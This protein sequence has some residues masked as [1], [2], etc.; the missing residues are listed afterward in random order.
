MKNQLLIFLSL[1][2]G[3][4]T[5]NAQSTCGTAL[6]ASLGS[7]TAS[8]SSST[9]TPVPAHCQFSNAGDRYIWYTFT[10][11]IDTS[12]RVSTVTSLNTGLDT[13]ISIFDGSCSALSC[14]TYGD[15]ES[16]FLTIVEFDAEA[17][18]TYYIVFD[19]Y[20]NSMPVDFTIEQF[21]GGGGGGGGTPTAMI[22]FTPQSMGVSSEC[23]VDM[24]ND[25]FD[26]IVVP[27]G[28]SLSI[29]YQSTSVPGTFTTQNYT[30]SGGVTNAPS[31]SIAGGDMDNNGYTDL[32]YGG[33]NGASIIMA[34]ST[35]TAYSHFAD[36]NYIFS[37]RTNVVD[38][39][40]NGVADAFVCHDVDAN[41]WYE[42][43]GDGTFIHHQGGLGPNAGNY[44]SVWIDYDND[45]DIDLFIAKCGSDA[46][47]QLHRNNGDGTFTSVGAA[48]GIADA[49]QTWSSA[50]A[51][52]DNDGDM[53]AFIGAS[54]SSSGSHKFYKNNGDGTF[55]NITAGSGFDDYPTYMGIENQPVD[56]NNDGWV[57]VYGLGGL[58]MFNNG[59]M[60]F[61]ASTVPAYAGATGDLN[62][63]GA[64]DIVYGSSIYFNDVDTNNY[65]IVSTVGVQS[66]KQGIGARIT[67]HSDLGNQI[68][69]VRSAQAFS[70][71]QTLNA[72]F[73]LGQDT[74]IDSVTICWPSGAVDIIYNPAINSHLVITEGSTV[75]I[76]ERELE[77]LN[78]YPNPANETVTL[79]YVSLDGGNHQISIL[80]IN[81]KMISSQN[82]ASKKGNNEQQISLSGMDAGIYLVTITDESGNAQHL[83]LVKE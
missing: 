70:S 2:V 72:H 17:G 48:A 21:N 3:C 52:Y 74:Q 44:G 24:N 26:D 39:N 5:L 29:L 57:D 11:S 62:H 16:A 14:I 64:I 6:T 82:F 80:D 34:N 31:W 15:D 33:G 23:V 37:Q 47:D 77:S 36:A 54:S 61:T 43:N 25:N 45:C 19:D 28:N 30:V 8:T 76:E 53:D 63:D 10:S 71:M 9:T 22:T 51:D 58:I 69:D 50:W 81:G 13:R 56:F 35:G 67:V 20:W 65:L 75:G 27:S 73:G 79:N 18:V 38:V 4:T 7:N 55:T 46:I 12:L 66:N 32:I 83:K 1:F 41:V 42:S 68:R 78:L 40:N 49:S 60:T 59:D